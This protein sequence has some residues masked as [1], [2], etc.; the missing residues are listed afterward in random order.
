M[1]QV[2]LKRI[3][4]A[5]IYMFHVIDSSHAIEW[6]KKPMAARRWI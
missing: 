3:Y 1:R 2:C 4:D 6:Q 5:T